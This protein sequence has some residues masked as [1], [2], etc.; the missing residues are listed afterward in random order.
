MWDWNISTYTPQKVDKKNWVIRLVMFTPRVMTIKISKMARFM[1]FH[2]VDY[3]KNQ[4]Q[5]G[6]DI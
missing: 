5:F 2:F 3:S 4:S 1:Y 6:Q